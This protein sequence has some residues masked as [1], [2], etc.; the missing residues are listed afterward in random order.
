M[1]AIAGR[2]GKM[3][4]DSQ[5]EIDNLKT[6]RA[7]QKIVRVDGWLVG[8]S[9]SK[10]PPAAALTKWFGSKKDTESRK[11][12]PRYKFN[13]LCMSP[14]SRLYLLDEAGDLEQIR[15]EFWA[16]GSG[17]EV[18]IGAMSR[19]ATA[20]EAVACAIRFASGCGGEIQIEK[21]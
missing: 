6:L 20:E 13:L 11:P 10:C 12:W 5:A 14:E 4:A 17:S 18:C 8:M 16:V 7:D 19:G 1:T 15:E 2:N 9:G 21:L 3:A